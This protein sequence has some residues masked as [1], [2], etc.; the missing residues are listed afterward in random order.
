M[1][2]RQKEKAKVAVLSSTKRALHKRHDRRKELVVLLDGRVFR[3]YQF[4]GE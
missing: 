4:I 2:D 1:L 3:F